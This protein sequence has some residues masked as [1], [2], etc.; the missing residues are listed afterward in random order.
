M[1]VVGRVSHVRGR[2]ALTAD[3]SVRKGKL[4]ANLSVR[5]AFRPTPRGRKCGVGH[6][7]LRKRPM[8]STITRGMT[9]AR[10]KAM[11]S[12]GKV[13]MDAVRRTVTTLCT[14]RVS[15]YLVRIGTPRFP[16]LSNDS[17]FF[18]R[19]VRGTNIMRRGTPGS[20]CVMGRGV[21]IGSRRA[22]SSLVVLPSSGFDIGI[23]VSFGSSILSGRF[24]A[25]GSLDRFPARLTTS[26][27]FIFIHRMR[28]L[29]RGGLVGNNSLSG[30]VIVCSRGMSRRILSGLTSG[31]SVPRGSMRS[32]N[33]VGGGPLMFSGRPTHRGLVSIVNSLTLVNG[34]VQNHM[35]TAH[36]KRGVGGRL[37]HVVHG[38]VGRGRIRTPICSPGDAPMVSVGHVHRLLPR[39]CPFLLISGVVRV[40]NGCV[41]NIGGVAD[42]RPFFANRFPRRP[43]VPNMLRIRTVTRANKL[44]ILGSMSRPRHCSACFVGVSNI[45]F[46]RG[47][48]PNSALVL[49]LRLLTPVHHNVS[50]VG[51]CM[52]MNS[53]LIDRTRFVTRVMGGGWV[54]SL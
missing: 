40:N 45:G 27:A 36:P 35:V 32:L 5:V 26:H 33:C 41:M 53:G 4:R 52:F 31:L 18:D 1:W 19:R 46:H 47:I 54:G 50:A 21:R 3:F 38:S 7:S 6:I 43:I 13:R 44:L 17:H 28:V 39:H 15:G 12:G 48:I 8:V 10:E 30:T 24:T 11:L 49:H 22:N 25:L 23:L 51:K 37:T 9:K 34:P 14:C 29:L 16:V 42:G 2:G 20:C